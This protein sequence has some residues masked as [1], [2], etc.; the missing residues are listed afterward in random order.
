MKQKLLVLQ[1]LLSSNF[2]SVLFDH[3]KYDMIGSWYTDPEWINLV[4][5]A[6]VFI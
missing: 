5:E 6:F 4:Q 1:Y 2:L 3:L